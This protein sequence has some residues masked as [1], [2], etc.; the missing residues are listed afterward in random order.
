MPTPPAVVATLPLTGRNAVGSS[1]G[2]TH[3]IPALDIEID[4]VRATYE[5]NVFGPMFMVK[6]FIPLLI[7]ARGLVINISSISSQVP[8]LFGAIYS[9]TKGAVDV[10]SRALRLE[11]KPLGVRVM[12]AM[13]GTVRSN[14][15]SRTHRTL[16]EGSYYE[17]VADV[18]QRRLTFSQSNG[19]MSTEV[20]ARRLASEA[21]RGEGWL[22][23]WRLFGTPDWFWYGGLSGLVYL[24]TFLPRYVSEGA[25]GIYWGVSSMTRRLRPSLLAKKRD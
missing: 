17:P 14:I 12:V 5:T 6:A 24:S 3:T 25:L 23:A 7:A 22:G 15:A 21:L 1:S 13:T 18:F 16:P 8:Y 2:R 9:S 10:W 11:L 20:Y 19:T 4:D